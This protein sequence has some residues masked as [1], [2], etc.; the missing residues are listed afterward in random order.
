MAVVEVLAALSFASL[1]VLRDHEPLKDR[2]ESV[3]GAQRFI[4]RAE[5]MKLLLEVAFAQR[6]VDDS[7][8]CPVRSDEWDGALRGR[9]RLSTFESLLRDRVEHFMQS[10]EPDACRRLR[11]VADP[12]MLGD[13][14]S[15]VVGPGDRYA[16]IGS[17]GAPRL[18]HVL[19]VLPRDPDIAVVGEGEARRLRHPGDD[20]AKPDR[21]SIEYGC[22]AGSIHAEEDRNRSVEVDG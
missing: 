8:L 7:A 1:P 16:R 15:Q 21:E 22:L 10:L 17:L 4:E 9:P 5:S 14:P 20:G 18:A 12:S 2:L 3:V 19:S 11:T 6:H 13:V